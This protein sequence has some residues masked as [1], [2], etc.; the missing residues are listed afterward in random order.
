MSRANYAIVIAGRK[1][2]G[3][4]TYLNKRAIKYAKATGKKV[5]II[6]VNGS[7]AYSKHQL[8]NER[9]FV[10]W[11]KNVGKGIKR[12]YLSDID[13]MLDMV[14]AHFKNGLIIFEDCTKYIKANPQDHIK[15]YL[16][17]H[18]M[19]NVDL[20]FTFHAL[21]FIPKFFF[22]MVSYYHVF[23]TQDILEGRDRELSK[24]FPNYFALKKAWEKLMAQDDNYKSV[25]VPTLI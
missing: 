18:R 5:L 23:K 20:F 12:F 2:T 4:S 17:D 15:A 6:D 16:V 19:W 11:C 21:M 3:K 7:P 14:Q 10:E 22:M 13:K 1:Y 9:S 24:R 25:T 8:L